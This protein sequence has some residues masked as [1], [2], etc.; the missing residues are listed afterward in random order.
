M[1]MPRHCP[2][3]RRPG[4]GLMA[5]PVSAARSGLAACCSGTRRH[6]DRPA[7]HPVCLFAAGRNGGS[8]AGHEG[9]GWLALVARSG[10]R[11][12]GAL[13]RLPVIPVVG[14]RGCSEPC[15]VG[16]LQATAGSGWYT[17]R[18]IANRIDPAD[19]RPTPTIWRPFARTGSMPAAGPSFPGCSRL[20][21]SSCFVVDRVSLPT[22]LLDAASFPRKPAFWCL[23]S[24]FLQDW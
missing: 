15:A 5:V 21:A 8:G 17:G 4:S 13:L 18:L 23:D 7:A 19:G 22:N 1:V 20:Q 6:R 3:W 24:R 10:Y 11:R 14:M 2:G 12:A 16:S 9:G